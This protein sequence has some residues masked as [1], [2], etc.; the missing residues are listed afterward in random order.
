MWD[1]ERSCRNREF[2]SWLN[3]DLQLCRTHK[4]QTLPCQKHRSVWPS[5][6]LCSSMTSLCANW[7]PLPQQL[8]GTSSP[9]L[10]APPPGSGLRYDF[11]WPMSHCPSISILG[12]AS[13]LRA[14]VACG[15]LLGARHPSRVLQALPRHIQEHVQQSPR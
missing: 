11:L 8:P 14:P 6:N 10:A 1:S 15:V 7:A 12:R 9:S 5:V 3:R 4:T 13:T 2:G